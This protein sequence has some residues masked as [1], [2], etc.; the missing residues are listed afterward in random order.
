M[1]ASDVPAY[2]Q[3]WEALL[4]R[5]AADLAGEPVPASEDIEA[6]SAVFWRNG[7][8]AYADRWPRIDREQAVIHARREVPASPTQV[9][10]AITD[11]DRI[12]AWFGSFTGSPAAWRIEF[13]QGIAVGTVSE[14]VSARR[15]VTTWRWDFEAAEIPDGV[16]TIDLEPAGD[17]CVI[18]LRHE[19]VAGS[20]AGYGAG[21]FAHLEALAAHLEGRRLVPA[22]WQAEWSVAVSMMR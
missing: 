17:G 3:G 10:A 7:P 9:W 15:L 5:L 1:P 22:D 13:E 19:R 14:C 11:P 12:S 4:G 20:L 18:H 8:D 6:L 16:L 21:W 2:G